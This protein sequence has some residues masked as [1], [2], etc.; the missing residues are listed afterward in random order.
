MKTETKE[1]RLPS[2][3]SAE[4]RQQIVDKE[5]KS[6]W[7]LSGFRTEIVLIFKREI[8]DLPA[9]AG[10]LADEQPEC[11]KE[12]AVSPL[13]HHRYEV[14]THKPPTVSDNEKDILDQVH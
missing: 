3:I 7:K 10:P 11:A 9:Q 12:Q 13:P 8:P 2:D 4:I 5:K 6:G 14:G 1:L